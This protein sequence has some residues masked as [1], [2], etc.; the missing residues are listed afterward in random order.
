MVV[1]DKERESFIRGTGHDFVMF[2]LPAFH[3]WRRPE[4]MA[5]NI[6]G[7]T[8]FTQDPSGYSTPSVSKLRVQLFAGCWADTE[9]CELP[10]YDVC[11]VYDTCC[12]GYRR[13]QG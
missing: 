6:A 3:V 13:V 1:W 12:E 8:G 10:V 4:G 9:C 5:E 2:R 7:G 11:K